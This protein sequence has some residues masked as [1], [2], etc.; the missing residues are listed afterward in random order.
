MRDVAARWK[1]VHL[2]VDPRRPER[3]R[4]LVLARHRRRVYE[5]VR[6]RNLSAR[7]C[8]LAQHRPTH[9][10]RND[11]TGYVIAM[12]AHIDHPVC[13]Y[14]DG[15]RRGEIRYHGLSSRRRLRRR[16]SRCRH[17]ALRRFLRQRPVAERG[18]L[19][20]LRR[21]LVPRH[22][23]IFLEKRRILDLPVWRR[24]VFGLRHSGV[25]LIP[26]VLR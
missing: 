8:V 10:G 12:G 15:N 6:W 17:P 23:G 24:R 22:L 5:Y 14:R 1:R 16:F 7:N 26:N 18:V 20:H 19:V 25:G 11:Q 3:I 2:H 21:L 13:V 9:A 4:R